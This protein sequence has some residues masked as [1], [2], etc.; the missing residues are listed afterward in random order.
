MVHRSSP[1]PLLTDLEEM[2]Q[3]CQQEPYVDYMLLR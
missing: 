2:I 3:I 1:S